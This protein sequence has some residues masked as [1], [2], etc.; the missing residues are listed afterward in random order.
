MHQCQKLHPNSQRELEQ[1]IQKC[2]ETIKMFK[3]IQ[4]IFKRLRNKSRM[5][6]KA[7]KKENRKRAYCMENIKMTK[8]NERGYAE[9]T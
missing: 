4:Q 6:N 5:K 1:C 8:Y 2:S 7:K 9:D 3:T